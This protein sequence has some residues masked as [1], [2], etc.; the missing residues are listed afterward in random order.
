MSAISIPV[1]STLP[2][3][4]KQIRGPLTAPLPRRE[5]AAPRERLG[6]LRLRFD[7][8]ERA[9]RERAAGDP[10][11]QRLGQGHPAA[12]PAE[13]ACGEAVA[14]AGGVDRLDRGC[15]GARGLAA[16]ARDRALGA[17]LDDHRLRPAPRAPPAPPPDRRRR[18][19]GTPR[20]RS[21]GR[22]RSRRAPRRARRPS[23]RP[24][25]SPGR[26][27]WWRRPHGRGRRARRAPRRRPACRCGEETCRWALTASASSSMSAAVRL[28]H[29]SERGQD[30]PVRGRCRGRR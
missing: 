8:A 7:P 1:N 18:R 30:R 6:Q 11:P 15:L 2:A 13:E 26:G 25:P 27:T 17:E 10:E 5:D 4:T 24:G 21:G 19:T 22:R 23:R 29:R 16:A 3:P 9:G 28:E 12:E 20:S 14:G